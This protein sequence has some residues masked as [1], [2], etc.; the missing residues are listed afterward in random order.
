VHPLAEPPK[1]KKYEKHTIDVVVDRLSVKE[2]AKR[3][4]TDSVETRCGSARAC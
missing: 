3:R 2:S 1:L 4:L